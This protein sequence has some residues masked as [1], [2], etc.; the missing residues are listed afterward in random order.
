M[1]PDTGGWDGPWLSIVIFIVSE[2]DIKRGL[3]TVCPTKIYWESVMCCRQGMSHKIFQSML[4]CSHSLER[5]N[6][7]SPLRGTYFLCPDINAMPW[8][9]S[10]ELVSMTGVMCFGLETGESEGN[11]I[12]FIRHINY[13][14]GIRDR[15]PATEAGFN[16]RCVLHEKIY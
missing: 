16:W 10:S 12:I 8:S 9:M 4:S 6:I 5:G 13:Q 3:C 11:T 7:I 14:S 15:G 2:M 1:R